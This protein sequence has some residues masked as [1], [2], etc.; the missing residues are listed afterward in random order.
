M[1][2]NYTGL[3]YNEFG[4]NEHLAITSKFLCI[5]IING[6]V[7]KFGSN[8]PPLTASSFFCISLLTVSWTQCNP[9]INLSSHT[10]GDI[11][12]QLFLH[13]YLPLRYR[14]LKLEIN[15]D[16]Q[17]CVKYRLAILSTSRWPWVKSSYP[18]GN[19]GIPP[20]IQMVRHPRDQVAWSLISSSWRNKGTQVKTI[21][22][23]YR[24]RGTLGRVI[25]RD[26]MH[27]RTDPSRQRVAETCPI[28]TRLI[29]N[30]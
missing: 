9:S 18:R 16:R 22:D 17:K 11:S 30:R 12:C 28:I 14:D 25:H 20:T 5:K 4:Y 24:I 27:I 1:N 26:N 2:S 8:E 6:N 10:W 3:A 21:Q 7:E 23:K 29:S 13:P 19:T 15:E